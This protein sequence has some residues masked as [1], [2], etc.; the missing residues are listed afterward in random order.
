LKKYAPTELHRQNVVYAM[1]LAGV[2]AVKSGFQ[3]GDVRIGQI[4]FGECL[5][6]EKSQYMDDLEWVFVSGKP[7]YFMIFSDPYIRNDDEQ[8]LEYFSYKSSLAAKRVVRALRL[9]HDTELWDPSDFISYMRAGSLN[10]RNPS[11]FGRW[12]FEV[13]PNLILNDHDIVDLDNFYDGV[14]FYDEFRNDIAIDRAEILFS[15]SYSLGHTNEVLKTL[16][17]WASLEILTG[18]NLDMIASA[19]WVDKE[20]SAFLENFREIRNHMA[21]GRE[22]D[23]F[24]LATALKVLRNLIRILLVEA[25]RLRI[26]DPK[27]ENIVGKFLVEKVCKD[28]FVTRPVWDCDSE[29]ESMAF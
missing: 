20:T 10:Q 5:M 12:P 17:L 8:Q 4:N 29:F 11:I 6:L 26:Q 21:H 14:K 3:I 15:A 25:I 13:Q 1:H 24:L 22:I 2:A 23:D 19:S 16:P 9:L 7:P 18:N 28:D 27:S